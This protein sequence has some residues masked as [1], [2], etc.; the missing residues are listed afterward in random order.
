MNNENIFYTFEEV[1]DEEINQL[2]KEYENVQVKI[3]TGASNDT[4]E[5]MKKIINDDVNNL[6]HWRS[7]NNIEYKTLITLKN[8]LRILTNGDLSSGYVGGGTSAFKLLLIYLGVKND[9]AEYLAQEYNP[10]SDK[11]KLEIDFS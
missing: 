1:N 10:D 8:G 4:L 6:I 9:T 2:N 11:A 7:K 5:L 3:T